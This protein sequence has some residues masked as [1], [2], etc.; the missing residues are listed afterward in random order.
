M[1]IRIQLDPGGMSVWT[2]YIDRLL[3]IIPQCEL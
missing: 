2:L 1:E 3:F